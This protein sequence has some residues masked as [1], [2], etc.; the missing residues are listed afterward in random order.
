MANHTLLRLL[1]LNFWFRLVVILF[2]L[3]AVGLAV[4]VPRFWQTSPPGFRPEIRVSL[5]DLFQA[6]LLRRSARAHDAAG[7]EPKALSAWRSAL[8]NNPFDQ[9]TLRGFVEYYI[10]AKEPDQFATEEAW[11]AASCLLRLTQ[12]NRI[13]AGLVARLSGRLG[14]FSGVVQLLEPWKA[15]LS[16]Q[17]EAAYL[18]ALFRT[19]RAEEF[20]ARWPPSA[21]RSVGDPELALYHTAYLAGWGPTGGRSAARAALTAAAENPALRTL[22]LRLHVLVCHKTMDI[23]GHAAL[24]Q[25]LELQSQARLDD[26]IDHWLLLRKAGRADDA[27][28]LAEAYTGRPK[29]PPELG[30]LAEVYNLLGLPDR[31]KALL[32]RYAPELA[33]ADAPWAWD[34]WSNYAAL[35]IETRDW[36]A[37]QSMALELRTL[38]R[39][40]RSLAGFSHFMEGRALHSLNQHEQALIAFRHAVRLGFPDPSF[41][42][43]AGIDFL[44]F[45]MPELAWETLKAV[46]KGA[47]SDFDY[48]LAM[49]DA[50]QSLKRDAA[51]LFRVTRRAY[52]LRP[53]DRRAICHYASAL[54]INRQQPAE[55]AQLTLQWLA[56]EPNLSGAKLLHSAALA[57]NQRYDEASAMMQAVHVSEISIPGRAFYYCTALEIHSGL[58]QYDRAWDDLDRIK[59]EHLFPVQAAWVERTRGQL[60][61]RGGQSQASHP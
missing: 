37:L 40:G 47:A 3:I 17:E 43:R 7:D 36:D 16:P 42:V 38:P 61:P 32:K 44:R 29:T 31:A 6:W 4:G 48:W 14:F 51:A 59:P 25:K 26:L 23:E 11:S 35:L 55:A 28:G 45:G 15:Q 20:A 30:R 8:A 5:V 52:E 2:V 34:I 58:G 57:L 54:I 18:K 24:L 56:Q 50:A 49:S 1:I 41:A 10:T 33:N 27:R 9:K 13:E 46:E 21:E 22:A 19:G 60:P 39:V 12:T 53:N